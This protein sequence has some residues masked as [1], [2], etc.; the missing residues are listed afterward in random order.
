AL[1][2]LIKDIGTKKIGFY[3]IRNTDFLKDYGLPPIKSTTTSGSTS[4]S[5]TTTSSNSSNSSSNS[6][7]SG[8]GG[9]RKTGAVAADDPKS[10]ARTLRKFIPRGNGREKVVTIR[11]E[12]KRLNLKHNP[13]AFCFLLRS[14]FE[15]SAKAYCQDHKSSGLSITKNGYD[16]PLAEVLD[17]ITNHL[18]KNNKDQAMLRALHGAKTQ[19]TKSDGILSVTSMN[20][21]V[22]NQRFSVREGDISVLFNNIFPLLE[23]MNS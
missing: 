7:A 16:R 14:I 6:A 21:L 17:D 19:L 11:D 12:M 4:N 13:L 2:G 9:R 18:T 5:S 22:H 3:E 20:Q 10:V 1:D 8:A 23:A 15:V